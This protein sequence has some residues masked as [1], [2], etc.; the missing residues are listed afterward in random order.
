M[1]DKITLNNV[2]NIIDATTAAATINNNFST[3][4]TA[5]QNT[6]S[7][8]GT[9]PNQMEA[10]LD[11]NG[12]SIINIAAPQSL[13]SPARL[14]DIVAAGGTIN[15]TNTG[16]VPPGGPTNS[17]LQKTSNADYISGWTQSPTISSI[18]NGGTVQFPSTT[19]ILV[20]KNTT[21]ILTNKTIVG[22]STNTLN[23]NLTT[24]ISG[25][26]PIA[27]LNT[28]I[29]A[30]SSTFWRGDG[31][32]QAPPTGTFIGLET[33]TLSGTSIPSTVSW[34]GFSSIMVVY[35]NVKCTNTTSPIILLH[36]AGSYQ[37]SSYFPSGYSVSNGGDYSPGFDP[38]NGYPYVQNFAG[39]NYQFG[40]SFL[41]SNI[42]GTTSYKI[43]SGKAFAVNNALSTGNSITADCAWIGTTAVDGLLFEQN[44]SG[45]YTSGTANIYG[46]I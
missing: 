20:G 15:I 22:G 27:N 5:F 18:T 21:D 39:N 10:S 32:W 12:N 2:G 8:D 14:Q 29:G 23:V 45:S 42:Q 40:G 16:N 34:A 43:M 44:V 28:G 46:I 9:A 41:L 24:D 17:L 6:Y 37:T 3:I 36:S 1:T 30:T 33:L 13:S 19:D 4:Q 25:N 38:G 11:M 7:L 35:W 26:L 31:T